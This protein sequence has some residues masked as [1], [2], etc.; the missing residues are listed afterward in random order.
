MMAEPPFAGDAVQETG[1]WVF[2]YETTATE[3]GTPGVPTVKAFDGSE[4]APDPAP[5]AAVTVK[6]YAVPVVSPLKT[7]VVALV[8][9]V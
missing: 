8:E 9:Q 4:A 1:T 5:L 7:Q 2:R 6:V 3:E